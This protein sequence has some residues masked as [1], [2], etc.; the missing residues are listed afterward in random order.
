MAIVPHNFFSQV[1][2]KKILFHR[3]HSKWGFWKGGVEFDDENGTKL[4]AD[5]VVLATG[6]DGKKK[7]QSIL[8]EPFRSFLEHPSGLMPLYR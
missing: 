2:K 8:P 6:Y 4:D 7:L 3:T 5:V 1:E